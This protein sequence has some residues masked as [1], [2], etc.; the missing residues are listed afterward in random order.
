[1]SSKK[2]LIVD[3][4]NTALLMVKMSVSRGAYKI[5]TAQ[6]GVEAVDKAT[7]ELPDLILMDVI[8]PRMD[9]FEAVQRLRTIDSTKDIPII[10]VTTRG[11]DDNVQAGFEAGCND[12]LTKPIN[13]VELSIG[14]GVTE[15]AHTFKMQYGGPARA[16]HVLFSLMSRQPGRDRVQA[17]AVDVAKFRVTAEHGA[18]P[19]F[20]RPCGN[21]DPVVLAYEQ[22]RHRELL[23]GRPGGGIER[24]LGGGV[25]RRGI[26]ETAEDDAV[27]GQSLSCRLVALG[28]PDAVRGADC[29]RQMGSDGAGLRGDGERETA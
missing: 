8:M 6:D 25:V 22:Q 1:M 2:I 3:D 5:L 28:Q 9:G 21:T 24:A 16:A 26:P 15:Q 17:I 27:G 4:A 11:E 12:Y 20:G 10:I 13:N 14:T 7:S 23:I 18:D 19:A 29:L